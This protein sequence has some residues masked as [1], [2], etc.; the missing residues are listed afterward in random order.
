MKI[1]QVIPYFCFGGAETMCENLT[2]ALKSQGHQVRV[3]SLYDRRTPIS[4][5]MEAAGVDIRYLD[6][7]LGLDV[8]MVG[9]LKKIMEEFRPDV[10]HTHLDV[11]K[12]AALAAKLAG[13]KR[14]VHTVHNVADKEAEGRTQKLVN[15]AYFRLGWAI[16]AALSPLVK[17]SI[18]SFYGLPEET[19]PMVYNGVDL[20]RCIPKEDYALHGP[21][22]IHLGRFNEQKNHE[23]LL[24]AFAI[25][26]KSFPNAR[27]RLLGEGERMEEMQQLAQTLGIGGHTDFLGSQSNVYP[28][29]HSADLFLLPSR[30][31]GMP[32]TVIEA[33][34]T[35]LP[36]VV[37]SVG[38]L[39][40][41]LRQGESGLLVDAP[42]TPEAVAAAA[43][44][45]LS[46]EA[47]RRSLG[48]AARADSQKFSAQTMAEEYCKLYQK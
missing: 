42:A 25:V 43:Q 32:M 27:L 2:Y 30:Y 21:T 48:Q 18:L 24:A 6:K 10:V 9:K 20:G 14:C 5:R 39:A 40:D 26:L 4:D 15:G 22:L 46:D 35:G 3:V 16:P 8:S 29:L 47:L 34:G 41:M 31:E 44:K 7:K 36:I 11:I 17:D 45:L 28:H 12:Y 33:M 23:C 19:V 38:G 37:S 13:V 1:L